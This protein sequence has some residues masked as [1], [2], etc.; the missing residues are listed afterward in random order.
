[1]DGSSIPT[2]SGLPATD[3]AVR[4]APGL[5]MLTPADSLL[6]GPTPPPDG[7]PAVR[8]FERAGFAGVVQ[9]VVVGDAHH[10]LGAL[11][12]PGDDPDRDGGT[13]GPGL[14]RPSHLRLGGFA[15]TARAR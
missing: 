9:R 13:V 8:A 6:L 5:Y 10:R 14:G 15:R 7:S 12:D 2:H 1:M 4:P 11:V 3:V